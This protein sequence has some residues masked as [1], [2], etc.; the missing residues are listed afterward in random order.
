MFCQA[1]HCCVHNRCST[2]P[3][4]VKGVLH[5]QR[6]QH[7]KS[8]QHCDCEAG[9]I[10]QRAGRITHLIKKC[11]GLERYI[12]V[13]SSLTR[14]FSPLVPHRLSTRTVRLFH[15]THRPR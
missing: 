1:A 8:D 3:S 14:S 15:L 7:W 2:D 10:K 11:Y 13:G 5:L 9:H 6:P 12:A 4:V